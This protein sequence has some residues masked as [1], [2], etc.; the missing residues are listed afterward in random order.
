MSDSVS[1]AFGAAV[2]ALANTP[3][4]PSLNDVYLR[5]LQA[6]KGGIDVQNALAQQ[7]WSQVLARHVDANGNPDYGAAAAEAANDPIAAKGMLS[8]L[9]SES[10]LQNEGLSRAH[11]K[12]GWVNG[13][14]GAL[15]DDATPDQI[16]RTFMSGVASHILTPQ[17]AQADEAE[18]LQKGAN[19]PALLQQH[20]L[21]AA[22]SMDQYQAQYGTAGQHNLGGVIVP[23]L[24]APAG[25]GGA[26]TQP[27]GG[28]TMGVPPAQPYVLDTRPGAP[29]NSYVPAVPPGGGGTQPIGPAGAPPVATRPAAAAIP[30][31]PAGTSVTLH[32]GRFGPAGPAA[33]VAPTATAAPAAP[34]PAATPVAPGQPTFTAPPPGQNEKLQADITA[35][36]AANAGMKAQQDR[37]IFGQHALEA[38]KLAQ[39]TGPG[40]GAMAKAF[41][42]LQA[43]GV[44]TPEQGKMSA[45]DY[46]Q[47]LVKNLLRFAQD[48][49]KSSGTDL[50]LETKLHEN[51]NAD[52]MLPLANRTVLL[53]DMGILKRDI[54]QTQ[55]MPQPSAT[56]DVM[57]HV[58]SFSGKIAPEAFMWNEYSKP[59][60]DAIEADYAKKQ[61]TQKL[62]DSLELAVRRGFIPDPRKAVAA[63]PPVVPPAAKASPPQP[64]PLV[65]PGA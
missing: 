30:P 50:G 13:A 54:A 10:T 11:L 28:F 52:E 6:Q 20:R 1:P 19:I 59:E 31:P 33:P 57:K 48:A 7:R 15:P 43:Q 16:H 58:G 63:P 61:Q 56:G 27:S 21:T 4:I 41:A 22:A 65:P 2:N 51:A 18:F 26:V 46:R 34:A 36:T 29:P 23:Y 62:H 35:S 49:G 39:D 47:L 24:Q 8:G 53:Q 5:S 44:V 17:E 14:L 45:T 37:L 32:G 64:N 60:R 40:T 25:K 42:F 55:E 3:D 12:L 38:L 9:Q